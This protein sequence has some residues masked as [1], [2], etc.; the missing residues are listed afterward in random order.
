MRILVTINPSHPELLRE[1][2]SLE[3]RHRAERLRTL[4]FLSL[5]KQLSNKPLDL[6]KKTHPR[7]VTQQATQTETDA[8]NHALQQGLSRLSGIGR[9]EG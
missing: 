8:V 5:Q 4:A 2:Q 3:P 6:P 7:P 9:K 1:M